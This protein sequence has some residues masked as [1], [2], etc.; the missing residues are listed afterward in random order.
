MAI[1]QVAR[2]SHLSSF[3]ESLVFLILSVLMDQAKTFHIFLEQFH[4]SPLCCIYNSLT[5]TFR[6]KEVEIGSLFSNRL[7]A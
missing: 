4:Q 3:S 1:F 5:K 2:G 6:Y 7:V